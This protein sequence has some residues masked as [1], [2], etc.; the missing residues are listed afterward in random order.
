[1]RI[2]YTARHNHLRTKLKQ[3]SEQNYTGNLM[4]PFWPTTCRDPCCSEFLSSDDLNRHPFCKRHRRPQATTQETRFEH[5][6]SNDEEVI[7]EFI[8]V[9]RL[10]EGIKIGAKVIKWPSP[11][12]PV[13]RWTIVSHLPLE[14]SKEQLDT[15]IRSV[16]NDSRFF[17]VCGTCRERNPNGWMH[18]NTVCQGCSGAVY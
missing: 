2:R 11:S 6:A 7:Q 18:D 16:L 4:F 1:M 5:V 12:W 14:A 10:K 9:K 13:S 15:E 8:R 3:S 17:G